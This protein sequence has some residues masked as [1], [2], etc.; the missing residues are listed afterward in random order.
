MFRI[1]R[2]MV[3]LGSK[4]TV[5]VDSE[6]GGLVEADDD[7][8]DIPD[9]SA[10]DSVPDTDIYQVRENPEELLG[11]AREKSEQI[12]DSA[13]SQAEQIIDDARSQAADILQQSEEEAVENRQQAWDEGYVKGEEE[14]KRSFDEKIAENEE[15]LRRVIKELHDER[16]QTYADMEGELVD[17]ALQVVR[18]VINPAEET[19]GGI[20]ESMIR[21]AI[22][23]IAPD[24]KITLRVSNAD[25]EKYFSEGSAVFELGSGITV[26]TSILK[27]H[28]LGDFDC[29]ID[30]DDSTVNASLDTQLKH[31]QLAF[32]RG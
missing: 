28:S 5:R 14:G 23:Q 18:K 27:D 26:S 24:D 1:E 15:S 13:R 2:H 25:Y 8:A 32:H 19:I 31:I 21:N 16:E 4:L 17:L 20:F 3:K 6:T 10:A 12:I 9:D 30:K 22:R 11:K 7:V 29:I